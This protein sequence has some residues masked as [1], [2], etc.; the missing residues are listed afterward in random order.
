MSEKH[1]P[2]WRYMYGKIWAD[3]QTLIAQCPREFGE[4]IV[5][6]HNAHEELVRV[7]GDAR[8]MIEQA[9]KRETFIYKQHLL[10]KIDAA[11]TK[12]ES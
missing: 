1:T 9:V 8:H 10:N 4:Q 12:A 3:C 11:L 7:L 2:E 6:E 5:R